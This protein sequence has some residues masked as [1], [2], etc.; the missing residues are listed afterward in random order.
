MVVITSDS[1]VT[2]PTPN[3]SPRNCKSKY[4][5]A[6]RGAITILDA[7]V[8]AKETRGAPPEWHRLPNSNTLA[9][10]RSVL[11]RLFLRQMRLMWRG[12]S[13]KFARISLL[14]CHSWIKAWYAVAPIRADAQTTR[15]V[16]LPDNLRAVSLGRLYD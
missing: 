12:A 13:G 3:E 6:R 11:S 8:S 15:D 10:T 2:R 5:E 4:A 16:H 7:S 14:P 9:K 1:S